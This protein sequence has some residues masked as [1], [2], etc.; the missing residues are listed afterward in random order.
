MIITCNGEM[1]D[2]GRKM[3][4]S[5]PE[6]VSKCEMSDTWRKMINRLIVSPSR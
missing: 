4:N 3:I 5:F 1:G 2:V 6:V